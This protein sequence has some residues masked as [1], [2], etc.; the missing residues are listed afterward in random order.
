M[1]VAKLEKAMGT[2]LR[3]MGLKFREYEF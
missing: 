1:A 2:T 3:T